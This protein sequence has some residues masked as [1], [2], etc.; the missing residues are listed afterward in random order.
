MCRMTASQQQSKGFPD[1]PEPPGAILSPPLQT[2]TYCSAISTNSEIL[3]SSDKAISQTVASNT[4]TKPTKR[5]REPALQGKVNDLEAAAEESEG[6]LVGVR[7]PDGNDWRTWSD[8]Y[9]YLINVVSDTLAQEENMDEFL[10]LFRDLEIQ[11]SH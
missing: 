1:H 3:N 10:V 8:N 9:K 11:Y 6:S 7:S 5:V 4:T 2:Q